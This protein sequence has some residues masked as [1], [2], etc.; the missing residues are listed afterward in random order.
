MVNFPLK[1]DFPEALVKILLTIMEETPRRLSPGHLYRNR[2]QRD[3]S[4]ADELGRCDNSSRTR[5]AQRGPGQKPA[6]GLGEIPVRYGLPKWSLSRRLFYCFHQ[7]L[8]L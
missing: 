3:D 2:G 7:G 8:M 4:L 6:A 5:V 1:G